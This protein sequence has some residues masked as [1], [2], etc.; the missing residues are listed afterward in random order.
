LAVSFLGGSAGVSVSET[1]VFFGIGRVWLTHV[2]RQAKHRRRT[3][4]LRTWRSHFPAPKSG[5][6]ES[7][8]GR[9]RT[10]RIISVAT[11]SRLKFARGD[12]STQKLDALN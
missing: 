3:P 6:Y 11:V 7:I 8:K 9:F 12:F 5:L 1:V 2:W 4:P 10:S